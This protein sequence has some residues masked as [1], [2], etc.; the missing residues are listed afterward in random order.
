MADLAAQVKASGIDVKRIVLDTD[1]WSGPELAD[2]WLTSGHPRHRRP[3][4]RATSPG[5]RR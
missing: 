4:P 2:G 1:Y 5:C 3:A